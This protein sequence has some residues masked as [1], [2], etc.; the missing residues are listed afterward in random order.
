MSVDGGSTYGD[1]DLPCELGSGTSS[2][3]GSEKVA[4]GGMIGQFFVLLR[5]SFLGLG[6]VTGVRLGEVLVIFCLF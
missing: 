5:T 2:S 3:S 1:P 6:W 4:G